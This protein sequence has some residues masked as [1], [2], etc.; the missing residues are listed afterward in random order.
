MGNL[1][2]S[3]L[4]EDAIEFHEY[5]VA[6]AVIPFLFDVLRKNVDNWQFAQQVFF[7]IGNLAFV[8]DFEPIILECDGVTLA[9]EFLRNFPDRWTMATDTIFFLKNI[10][11]GGPGRDAILASGATKYVLETVWRNYTQSEL[12]ELSLNLFFDLSFS[13][14]YEDLTKDPL[15]VQFFI[16]LLKTHR[17]S[18]PPLLECVRT[19]ARI[20][21]I[22]N[23]SIRISM[24]KEGLMDHLIPLLSVH[25]TQKVFQNQLDA[26]FYRISR[27]KVP[28]YQYSPDA[29]T[30]NLMEVAARAIINQKLT[31]NLEYCPEDIREYL[32]RSRKCD[33]CSACYIDYHHEIILPSRYSAWQDSDLP[34]FMKLC[35]KTCLELVKKDACPR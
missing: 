26:V 6:E 32:G 25:K 2:T 16:S 24:I 12:V 1:V 23:E 13:G 4:E 19:L 8:S 21:T 15:P 31:K 29:Q 3:V 18:M 34:V 28:T 5:I 20:Y 22:S 30:P 7:A 9:A 11:Y 14:G 17:N 33:L 27:E 10:A 35:S